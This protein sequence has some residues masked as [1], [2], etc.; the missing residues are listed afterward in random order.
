MA[1]SQP[2]AA[3][4][5][6]NLY[7]E[8]EVWYPIFRL[9]EAGAKVTIVGPEQAKYTSKLG[10]P[11]QADLAAAEARASDFDLVV[12]PG[13]FAPDLMRL[14]KPMVSLV[15][16]MHAQGKI[17]AAIC[18]GTWLLASAGALKGRRATGAPSIVDDIRNAGGQYVDEA[19][20]CD[21][22]LVTSRK[23]ADIP[24]FSA[25]I[26]HALGDRFGAPAWA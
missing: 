11:V 6:E 7:Q 3:I 12:V 9:Q 25:G 16:E 14:C 22:N 15:G 23:P 26:L 8:M 5:V 4:L 1:R 24:A 10:Y 13:G 18:H 19:V 2:R 17:V 21:G 20:V